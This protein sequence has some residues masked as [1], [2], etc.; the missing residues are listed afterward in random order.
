MC[1]LLT[2]HDSSS[3]PHFLPLFL[4]LARVVSS[5]QNAHETK[6]HFA[7]DWLHRDALLCS[8]SDFCLAMSSRF[9]TASTVT[10]GR[11]MCQARPASLVYSNPHKPKYS[12]YFLYILPWICIL[13]LCRAAVGEKRRP[14]ASDLF[15]L[16]PQHSRFASR[17]LMIT[18]LRTH[19]E[20]E[21]ENLLSDSRAGGGFTSPS[22]VSFPSELGAALPQL[23]GWVWCSIYSLADSIARLM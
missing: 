18:K 10:F 12:L 23:F 5:R 8:L 13:H 11:R 14:G 1:V 19:T 2:Q 16:H 22:T 4:W 20:W 21:R 15:V 6:S 7:L 3:L 17:L 9:A